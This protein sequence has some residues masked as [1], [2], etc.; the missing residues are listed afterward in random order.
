[1][2]RYYVIE[3][4]MLKVNMNAYVNIQFDKHV[5]L[6]ML[7][8]LSIKLRSMKL[9]SLILTLWI[10]LHTSLTFSQTWS[11]PI[12]IYSGGYNGRPDFTID[13]LGVFHCVWPHYFAAN[14][15]KIYYSKSVDLGNTWSQ[16]IDISLNNSLWMDNPH[17]IS[18]TN[19]ILFVTYDYNIMNTEGTLVVLKIFDGSTWNNFDT[20]SAGMPSSYYNRLAIDYDNKLYCFWYNGNDGGKIFY[21]TLQNNIW[22]EIIKPYTGT[23]EMYFLNKVVFDD[24]NNLHCIGAHH[25]AGQSGYSDRAIY[26]KCYDG[27]WGIYKELSNNTT[28]DGLDIALNTSS[29]PS[30]T[31]GQYSSNTVPPDL[32]SF[33]SSF[34]GLDWSLPM[35]L[36]NGKT[37]EQAIGIDA[38]NH[39]FIIDSEKDSTGYKQVCYST[40]S[41]NEWSEEI[42]QHGNFGTYSHKIIDYNNKFYLLY[43]KGDSVIGSNSFTSVQ[44][45][46][47]QNTIGIDD[48][49]EIVPLI[50]IYPNPFKG[51][52]HITFELTIN[53]KITV[54]IFDINGE[55][56]NTLINENKTQGRYNINWKGKD[57]NGKEVSTGLY[58]IRFQEGSNTIMRRVIVIK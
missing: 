28:R 12:N 36:A 32:G 29:L 7:K 40:N 33:V 56:V 38:F 5:N 54:D 43:L 57:R 10:V 31:W 25:Y 22:S 24:Q 20:L 8:K 52:T 42:I 27:L 3:F 17:I 23:N 49:K 50:N 6:C 16:P 19:N 39:L 58:F 44:M 55:L 35:M 2:G 9:N 51:E 48:E 13:K 46:T 15:R 14:Y 11:Q 53:T 37:E 21:R 41:I 45:I 1:M 30:V 34:N 47:H 4:K 26:F 18:D